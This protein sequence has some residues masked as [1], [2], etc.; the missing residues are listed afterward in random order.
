M[1]E[2]TNLFVFMFCCIQKEIREE[3][4]TARIV[5][6]LKVQRRIDSVAPKYNIAEAFE[7]V[8]INRPLLRRQ[9]VFMR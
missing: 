8:A 1:V 9:E 3:R 5:A 6:M 2:S 4:S 7:S